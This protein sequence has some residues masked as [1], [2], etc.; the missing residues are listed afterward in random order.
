ME[1]IVRHARSA[2]PEMDIV[3]THFVNEGMLELLQAGEIPVSIEAHESV[4][5][6]YG[7]ASIFLAREVAQRIAGG[8]LTWDDYGGVHPAPEGNVIA[9]SM[10]AEM[11]GTAWARA[12]SDSAAPHTLPRTL[13]DGGSYSH[14]RWLSPAPAAN[15]SW[16]FD[17][18][19]WGQIEGGFRETFAGLP[20]LCCDTVEAETTIA[21]GG[22]MLG[23]F[24]LA[25]PDAAILECA[26]DGGEFARLDLFHRFSG[27]LH[28]PRTVILAAELADGPHEA[29]LRLAS[30]QPAGQ[31][32][33]RILQFA[34]NARA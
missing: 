25:G 30:Q 8:S 33:A 14:G 5:R 9:A 27:G 10:V 12:A 15:E 11:L 22:S 16:M 4:C 19:D 24:V 32:A 1:G 6:H 18:P 23:A 20:L 29:R 26:V 28:Y 13:V 31:A 34:V 21:F 2:Q 3:V 7:I 17:A